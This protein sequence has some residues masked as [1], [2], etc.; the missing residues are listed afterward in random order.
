MIAVRPYTLADFDQLV[1]IQRECFPPPFPAELWWRREQLASQ[2][3]HFPAGTLCAVEGDELVGSATCTR[4]HFDPA[5]PQHTW[6][7]VADDGYIRTCDPNGDTLYGID[8]AVRPAWRG[9]GVARALYQARYALVQRLGL[10]RF[11]A[12]SRMSGYHDHPELTPE[13]Y[14]AAIVAG[15]LADPVITP[16]IKAGLQPVCVLHDYVQDEESRNF[17]LLM[18][19]QPAARAKI[20][21]AS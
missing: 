14:A 10:L 11:L 1:R 15:R 4:I 20:E 6:A 3:A 17:A 5:H 21:G 12:G 13:Q 2:L 19:W 8:M 7:E 18:Q 9:R 16:Q